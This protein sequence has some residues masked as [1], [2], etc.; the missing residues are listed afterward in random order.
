MIGTVKQDPSF[1]P[2]QSTSLDFESNIESFGFEADF[3]SE[4]EEEE[5]DNSDSSALS[6][7]DN[8]EQVRF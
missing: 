5:S 4:E 7:T 2:F 1:Q 3:D 6:S 8:E